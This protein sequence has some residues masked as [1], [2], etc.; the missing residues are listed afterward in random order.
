MFREI[1]DRLDALESEQGI[2]IT[3]AAESGSRAWGFDSANSDYDVRGIYVRPHDWYLSINVE[4]KRDVIERSEGDLDIHL[5]DLRKALGLMKK[6]NP[7]LLEWFK[8]PVVYRQ[9]L[10]SKLIKDLIPRFYS[11]RRAS[12]HYLHMARGNWSRYLQDPI[13]KAKK[14]LYVIRPVLVLR[15]IERYPDPPPV[16]FN[17]LLSR[18][19]DGMDWVTVREIKEL[20]DKKRS[21]DELGEVLR[22]KVLH[23][24]LEGELKRYENLP[25]T[26]ED[27]NADTELL[28][29]VFRK[30]VLG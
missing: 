28:N 24:F 29:E 1:Q 10:E 22:N 3:Y 18:V 20:V 15:W 7:A 30:I 2:F 14:Y 16:E 25:D 21:G 4:N 5:W 19:F 12:Y 9:S 17:Y 26:V 23:L 13:V 11:P 27:S 6:S 8:S